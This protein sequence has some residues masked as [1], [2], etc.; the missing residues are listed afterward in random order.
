MQKT[1]RAK[2]KLRQRQANPSPVTAQFNINSSEFIVTGINRLLCRADSEY[3]NSNNVR[4]P[5]PLKS[6]RNVKFGFVSYD[7]NGVK[8]CLGEARLICPTIV[9]YQSDNRSIVKQCPIGY[10]LREPKVWYQAATDDINILYRANTLCRCPT[11][12]I[13]NDRTATCIFYAYLQ[14][15]IMYIVAS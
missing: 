12:A 7:D 3:T 1:Y 10:G 2:R 13:N 8:Y 5:D 9:G 6:P 11:T 15:C 4:A 14:L